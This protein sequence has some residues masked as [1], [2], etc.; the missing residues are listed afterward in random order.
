MTL[1]NDADRIY[2]NSRRASSVYAGAALVW[3]PT[4]Y[5]TFNLATAELVALSN[6]SVG[7]TNTASGTVSQGAKVMPGKT[8][9]KFYYEA[10][11]SNWAT[12]GS[13]G[14]GG[15]GL[16]DTAYSDM[17]QGA[18]GGIMLQSA[19]GQIWQNFTA[20][21]SLGGRASG[22]EFGF[23][24]DLDNRKWW[25]CV[26]LPVPVIWNG[27][28]IGDPATNVG[29]LDLPATGV[30]TPFCTFGGPNTGPGNKVLTNFGDVGFTARDQLPTGFTRGWPP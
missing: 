22:D 19:G 3:P 4:N 26:L 21:A 13:V 20:V 2:I 17:Q 7:V 11:L 16:V 10:T 18:T 1:L 25:C 23:A 29:G 24:V 30:L 9:G 27:N 14:V 12:G 6:G 28:A 8:T 15:V 5:S